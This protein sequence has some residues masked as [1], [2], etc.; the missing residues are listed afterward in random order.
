MSKELTLYI[1]Y[2]PASCW[3]VN[4][5]DYRR[6]F[7]VGKEKVTHAMYN[8]EPVLVT[9][10]YEAEVAWFVARCLKFPYKFVRRK[11]YCE[12]EFLSKDDFFRIFSS[13]LRELDMFRMDVEAWEKG[14]EEDNPLD[15]F[16][17]EDDD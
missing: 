8:E 1:Q 3:N 6:L 17:E 7:E 9:T 16:F 11:G 14:V 5:S 12:F 4:L 10:P 13:P 2:C 15:R